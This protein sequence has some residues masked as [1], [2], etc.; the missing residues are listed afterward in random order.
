MYDQVHVRIRPEVIAR[1]VGGD[2]TGFED[3]EMEPSP[4]FDSSSTEDGLNTVATALRLFAGVAVL[5]GT[6]VGLLALSRL[7]RVSTRHRVALSAIGWTRRRHAQAILLVFA[8]WLLAGVAF[9]LGVGVVAS[10]EVMVGLAAS[11][12]P[13]PD[14]VI[15][16]GLLVAKSAALAL[17]VTVL[18]LVVVAVSVVRGDRPTTPAA[19]PRRGIALAPP[20]PLSLGARQALFGTA[21]RGVRTSRASL[22]A[23]IVGLSA[24]IAALVVSSSIGLLQRD[25]SLSGQGDEH[26][27]DSGEALDAYER[28]MPILAED[29]RVETIAGLHILFDVSAEGVT[30]VPTLAI[31]V[32]RG[33]PQLSVVA[34]RPPLQPDEVAIGPA[35]LDALGVGV[36]DV[37]TLRT[38]QAEEVFRIVGSALFPEGD[39]RHDEGFAVTV[40]G[41]DRLVGDAVQNAAIHQVL[42][43]W[44]P[45][46]DVA[47]ADQELV[48]QGF[49]V[50]TTEAGLAPPTVANLGQVETVPRY[51]ALFIA[52][53]CLTALGHA[54]WVAVRLQSKDLSTLRAIGL[55]PRAT[56]A[57]V[58]CH[59]LVIVVLGLALAIPLGFAMGRHVWGP[60]AHGAHVVE[61]ADLPWGWV[62]TSAGAVLLVG[63]GL[64][65]ISAARA[66]RVRPATL[67]RAE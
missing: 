47:R 50:L 41:G 61:R 20:L 3:V 39:F 25:P 29:D 66:L 13:D 18:L 19:S 16:S 21:E 44:A 31:E 33:D 28:A 2:M 60:I 53:L 54:T 7:A 35:T 64:A 38:E 23:M 40:D 59:A 51:L 62:L 36:G 8:P 1:V 43:D 67:L 15:V 11:V 34:G 65:A 27:I 17:V 5:A 32:V 55:T 22:A 57:V 48:D 37:I 4:F 26:A 49:T 6:I 56:A 63:V 14:A 24:A 42:F 52:V 12:E 45:G 30:N 9:G 10:R 58:W 46:V